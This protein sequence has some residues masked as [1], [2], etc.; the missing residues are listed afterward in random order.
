MH[1]ACVLFQKANAGRRVMGD[2]GTS[3]CVSGV[4]KYS[5]GEISRVRRAWADT[6]PLHGWQNH[7]HIWKEM[8]AGVNKP[9][10]SIY[11]AMRIHLRSPG[12][13]HKRFECV[14]SRSV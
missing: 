3:H 5:R 7:C 2:E 10:F 13:T 6:R 12:V 11:C 9:T 1:A 4:T 8:D 14:C